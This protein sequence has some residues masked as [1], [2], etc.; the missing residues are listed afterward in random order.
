[1]R[2]PRPTGRASPLARYRYDVEA[3]KQRAPIAAVIG[4]EVALQRSARSWASA[5]HQAGARP[6]SRSAQPRAS[7]PFGGVAAGTAAHVE[8]RHQ[9][10]FGQACEALGGAPRSDLAALW[11]LQAARELPPPAPEPPA[12]VLPTPEEATVLALA[13][14]HYQQNLWRSPAALSYLLTVRGLPQ[15]LV[16]EARLGL[17]GGVDLL[18][19]DR[20]G[21]RAWPSAWAWWTVM[22]AI[23][24]P[25]A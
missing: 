8:L 18:L 15:E 25:G 13:L 5:L 4:R 20:P 14:E 1:M 2:T 9:L 17:G 3:I 11:A 7:D 6:P 16:H 21:A 12:E 23:A 22:A 19:R 24:T 10:S